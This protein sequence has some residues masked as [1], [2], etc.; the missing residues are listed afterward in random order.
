[1][2]RINDDLERK[3]GYWG[4]G[5]RTEDYINI[6]ESYSIKIICPKEAEDINR[7]KD[8]NKILQF[9]FGKL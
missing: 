8:D 1:L 5:N 2:W 4:K 3:I 6:I 7:D 9:S